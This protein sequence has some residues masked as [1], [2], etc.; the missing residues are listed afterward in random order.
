MAHEG[1][2]K[3]GLDLDSGGRRK[4]GHWAIHR[5]SY[6]VVSGGRRRDGEGEWEGAMESWRRWEWMNAR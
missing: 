2:A 6:C 4:R 5:Q 1:E 3:A